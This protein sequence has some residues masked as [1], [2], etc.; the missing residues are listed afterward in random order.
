MST[1]VVNKCFYS[2][3]Y[4]IE[5]IRNINGLV[6]KIAYISSLDQKIKNFDENKLAE[7][8]QT[9]DNELWR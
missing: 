1:L 6:K 7:E 9:T 4:L 8:T 3:N 5:L 2:C